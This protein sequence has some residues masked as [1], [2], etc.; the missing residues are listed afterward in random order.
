MSIQFLSEEQK[1]RYGRYVGEPTPL[2]LA[3]YFHLDDTARQL[4]KQ[5]RGDHNRLG[6][7]IQL[8]T[9]RFLGT[10]LIN[11]IDV[12]PGIVA[13]LA[14]Q[15]G[16][17]QT[18]CL[19]RYLERPTTH[20][21][22]AQIIKR[23]YGYQEF[24]QQPESWRL[25]R[26]LYE[27]A[28]VSD[29][30]PSILFDLTT[31]RLLENKILLPGVTVLVRLIGSVRERVNQR[32]W[33]LVSKLPTPEQRTKL[34]SILNVN[35]KTQQTP[36]DQL[37]RSPTRYSAP[38]LV[39]ALNR[40]V[41]IRAFGIRKLDVAKI[42]P[43]RL[44]SL[45]KT[46]LTVRAQ[47]IER[48]SDSRRIATLVAFIYIMEAIAT[49]DALDILNLL[50]KDL[51]SD[52]EREGKNQR[53]RTLK[54][55]D[56]SA[57][58]LSVACRVLLDPNCDD[59][60]VRSWVWQLM[61]KEQLES[62]V[63]QVE[64]LAK[65]KDDNYYRELL[66]HWRIVRRFLPSLLETIDFQANM[67]G[68]PILAAW[69]FLQSIEGQRQPKMENAPLGV[70][71]K[72]WVQW[73]VTE[74]GQVN[75]RAY[76]FCVL[77]QLVDCLRRRD[78][79]TSP[80]ERWSNPGA[81]LLQGQAW[82]SARSHVCRVLS[83]QAAPALELQVLKQQLDEAYQRTASNLPDNTAVRIEVTNGR[84]TLT[85]RNLDK[86]AEPESYLQLKALADTLLPHV[87]LPE[88]LLEIQAKTG[89]MDEFTHVNES[90]ARVNDLSTSIC[91]V[92]I[93][94]ACNITPLVR[95]DVPALTRGRL[96]WVEQNYIRPETLIR[97][98]VR[99]VDAQAQIP[100]AQM[101]GGGEVASADGLRF[102][103]PVRTLNAGPN[104]KYFGQGRG[105]TYYNFTSDQFTGFHGLVVPGTLKDSLVVLVGLLEQQTS[106]RP[107]ELMTD[108][109]GYSDVVFGLFWLLGYQFSPRLA[110]AGE[111]RFWRLDKNT[112]YGVLD[113]LARATVKTELIEQ[114]W[115]D[116]L[117][118]AGSLKLG[119]VSALEIMRALHRGKKPSTLAKAIAELGRI[120]K[121]L[122]LL[123]YVDDEDYRRRILTQLNRGESRHSLAR[124]V[125]FGRRGELRQAY[126]EGQE[127]Q[128]SA[129]GLV[130]NVLVLWNTYYLDVALNY[131]QAEEKSVTPEDVAR[132]SPLA[133]DHIN[134]L[135]RYH[136]NLPESLKNGGMRPLRSDNYLG[137]A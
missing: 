119:T 93:A 71:S 102:V 41:T 70:V 132:L 107:R 118:V 116:M 11:P 124:A 23:H 19:L 73:V 51:L 39:A 101:W 50:V 30:S 129:L 128:L 40:L 45:A 1:L 33:S 136:F 127:E 100:L 126:R 56:T 121:T 6:F 48:M 131:L 44:K 137:E 15:L 72:N 85:I 2:Q 49:D 16:I 82:E 21:E 99:L 42:P 63:T 112:D 83:L 37:R 110:D 90:F 12:P 9:V 25:L 57:L 61:S 64:D 68:K 31:A 10:F 92:L 28:W 53:L 114:N 94:S 122:Y 47:A 3:R 96:T 62:A 113:K 69:C 134:M 55:L 35:E 24:T 95:S 22:H 29:E 130:V 66:S 7:A 98:N 120:S 8:C 133:H 13:D 105:I 79:F 117:R 76:T 67:A 75:R 18:N 27:R 84:E 38:A 80:S 4:V 91:A 32:A 59:P 5:R 58:Q 88:V 89:F 106:L 60:V 36:L 78:L 65:P 109:S 77:E 52:S 111:A 81:K 87:D 46:A 104:S 74:D 97:A 54:D 14:Q 86:L 20:W 43:T 108:T 103:V 26:W 115:D 123:N 34:E 17:S 135:G 125:F